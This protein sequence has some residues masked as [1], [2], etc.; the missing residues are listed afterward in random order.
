MAGLQI[1]RKGAARK[2]VCRRGLG[3]PLTRCSP[4]TCTR[5]GCKVAALALEALPWCAGRLASS[6]SERCN[7]SGSPTFSARV[8][9]NAPGHRHWI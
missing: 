2:R 4:G 5:D 6:A 9:T 7:S 3:H 1:Q 8:S